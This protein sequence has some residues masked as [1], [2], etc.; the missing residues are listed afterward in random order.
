MYRWVRPL[1]FLFPAELAHRFGLWALRCLGAVGFLRDRVRKRRMRDLPEL[2]CQR[3][4]L[5]FATPLGV[6]AGLDK[7]G[8]AASG[9]FALGFGFVEVGTVTPRAQ[10]GNPAPRLFRIPEDQALINRM[11]FNN[12]GAGEVVR[13]LRSVFRP[14]P[15]GLNIG[16]NKVTPE[17]EAV[18]DYAAAARA[19][20][21]AADYVVINVS[22]PNTPG[23]R[24]L[25]R[26]ERLAPILAAVKV[27]ILGKPL[28]VKF[29]PDLEDPDLDAV[30]DAA[31]AA[32]VAGLIATNTTATRPSASGVYGEAGGLS[33]QPLKDAARRALR[34]ARGRV[35]SEMVLVGVGGMENA[36]DLLER[37]QDGASLLQAYT[38]LIY[39]GPGWP[40]SVSIELARLL[41]AAG[42]RSVDEAVGSRGVS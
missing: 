16:K 33:G 12:P 34:R 24:D 1:L 26:P 2:S 21:D 28:L 7:S 5:H 37:L 40:R 15:L 38:A 35:G 14:G 10:P 11:G 4:G 30:C 13:N 32:G 42:F 36:A 31:R 25:Q 29:S 3:F 22:S 39:G 20:R 6:G 19:V 8:T 23:L 18:S 41:R 9:L 27:E 17:E